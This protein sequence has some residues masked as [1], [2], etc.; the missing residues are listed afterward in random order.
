MGEFFRATGRLLILE[1]QDNHIVRP[2]VHLGDYRH[3]FDQFTDLVGLINGTFFGIPSS[4][5]PNMFGDHLT[6]PR[7]AWG[8]NVPS[9]HIVDRDV[10]SAY[11][12]PASDVAKPGYRNR[13]SVVGAPDG[14]VTPH[15]GQPSNLDEFEEAAWVM[16]GAG[17]L[18]LNG[19]RP[20][21]P[22]TAS[23]PLG[24]TSIE[25]GQ[26]QSDIPPLNDRSVMLVTKDGK[27]HLGV[28]AGC[29]AVDASDEA[30]N[31]GYEHAFFLDGGGSTFLAFRR[32]GTLQIKSET[33]G[34]ALQS[35]LGVFKKPG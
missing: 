30:H 19:K 8:F 17:L 4:G 14:A 16:G 24:I 10:G 20:G 25:G 29:S 6:D 13:W 5:H 18:L 3:N 33:D 2:I 15:Q 22:T 32:N 23:D 21:F 7:L 11:F 12:R 9:S 27:I 35:Y 1:P 28:A 31:A 26:F 34:R